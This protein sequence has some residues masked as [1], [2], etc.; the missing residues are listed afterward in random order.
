MLWLVARRGT[1][2]RQEKGRAVKRAGGR[3]HAD[4]PPPLACSRLPAALEGAEGAQGPAQQRR[5]GSGYSRTSAGGWEGQG[6]CPRLPRRRRAGEVKRARFLR[7]GVG[8]FFEGG[9]K[10]HGQ[11]RSLSLSM[12]KPRQSNSKDI[13]FSPFHL[14]P[15]S[16][17]KEA[18][19]ALGFSVGP[20]FVHRSTFS[21]RTERREP[22]PAAKHGSVLWKD[23]IWGGTI[24]HFRR[25]PLSCEPQT[26]APGWGQPAW[27]GC[28]GS[29]PPTSPRG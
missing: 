9:G 16:V 23:S 28:M 3:Q 1:S 6:Q 18:R 2:A 27:R 20:Y 17:S 12:K 5:H 19:L 22:L 13:K 14:A 26:R 15:Q 21:P 8:F 11:E 25:V 7:R 4:Q 24:W 10:E 29:L